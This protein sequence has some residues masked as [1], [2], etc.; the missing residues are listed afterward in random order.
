[1]IFLLLYNQLRFENNFAEAEG[2]NI[3]RT[4]AKV[5]PTRRGHSRFMSEKDDRFAGGLIC[6]LG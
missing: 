1:M 5:P 2:V 6:L 4:E 3:V